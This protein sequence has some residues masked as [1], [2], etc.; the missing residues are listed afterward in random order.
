MSSWQ[1]PTPVLGPPVNGVCPKCRIPMLTQEMP[2]LTAP[3]GTKPGPDG[4]VNVTDTGMYVTVL[5]CP[6]CK[7]AHVPIGTRPHFLH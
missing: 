1:N 3:E 6:Q 7:N 2:Y 4:S 5:F